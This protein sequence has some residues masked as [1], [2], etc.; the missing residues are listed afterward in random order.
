MN[1]VIGTDI[2][3]SR[4]GIQQ[5][6]FADSAAWADACDTVPSPGRRNSNA[7]AA[8]RHA[9]AEHVAILIDLDV[10][11]VVCRMKRKHRIEGSDE[12]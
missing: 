5:T 9:L 12:G 4:E 6:H 2:G 1:V 7:D 10:C 3:R 11:H 8:F